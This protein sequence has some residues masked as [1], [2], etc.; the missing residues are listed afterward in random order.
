MP[1]AEG[2]AARWGAVALLVRPA[3]VATEVDT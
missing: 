1:V 3:Y 2:R